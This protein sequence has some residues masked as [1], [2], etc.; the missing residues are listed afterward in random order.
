DERQLA[1]VHR[2]DLVIGVEVIGE[3]EAVDST[4]IK[5][6][7]L[8][9]VWEFKIANLAPEGKD[10]KEGEPVIGFDPSDHV[11]ELEDMQN[12]ADSA[13]KKLEKKRDDAALA[14]RDD[15][16]KVAEAEA[17]LRKAKLKI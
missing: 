2:D 8:G 12:E 10:V 15:E 13:Q 4:D 14:R 5:P 9:H 16:L 3:L 1:D 11:H 17:G 7:P 6:P